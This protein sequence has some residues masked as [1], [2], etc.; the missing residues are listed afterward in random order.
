[1]TPRAAPLLADV[2]AVRS[3]DHHN[4]GG[5]IVPT[6]PQVTIRL[7]KE[8]FGRLTPADRDAVAAWLRDHDPRPKRGAVDAIVWTADPSQMTN[9][10]LTDPIDITVESAGV[11]HTTSAPP[12]NLSAAA[13]ENIASGVIA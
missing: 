7:T 3:D 12:P 8:M 13:V 2:T 9:A 11:E 5:H 1:V 10:H 4:E 6:P